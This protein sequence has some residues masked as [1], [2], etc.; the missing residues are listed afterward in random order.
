MTVEGRY[1]T[2]DAYRYGFNGTEKD[3]EL[4]GNGNHYDLG[5]RS[6]DTRIGRMFSMDPRSR[7]YPWQTTYAY[8]RNSPIKFIDYL[9]GGDVEDKFYDTDGNLIHDD[10]EGDD[11]YIVSDEGIENAACENDCLNKSEVLRKHATRAYTSE[12]NAAKVWAPVG[13]SATRKDN[14]ERA[15][16]LLKG[17]MNDGTT[18]F[19]SGNTVTGQKS[20][21]PRV[22]Q[23]VDPFS[24]NVLVEGIN[25]LD[26]K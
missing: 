23:E 12:Q 11:H 13:Y 18:L 2:G 21:N 15:T 6:F 20:D 5:L 17:E 3:N 14:M 22:R 10:G 25:L 9:G 26:V 16:I 1:A 24:S 7:E 19:V 4:K 8:H